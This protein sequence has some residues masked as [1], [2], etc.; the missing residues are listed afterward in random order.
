M[1]WSACVMILSL[2]VC[3][4]A[5]ARIPRSFSQV[6]EPGWMTIEVREDVD[7]ERAW[8]TT[9]AILVRDFDIEFVEKDNGYIRTAWMYTWSGVYQQN[10]RVRV[11]MKFS[12]DR[13]SIAI[14]SEAQALL[15]ANIW[16]VGVDTRQLSTLKTDLMG[17][18]GRT[19]K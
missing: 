3:G 8:E 11:T 1:R 10:Y 2:C 12:E 6:S 18:I 9:F 5:T 16:T 17:T 14:K 7:F 19:T 15:Q 4:C 13:K